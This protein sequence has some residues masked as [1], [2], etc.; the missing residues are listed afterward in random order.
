M[1]S[2]PIEQ[3]TIELIDRG[4]LSAPAEW[5]QLT[6]G[7]SNRVWHLR[8]N[9]DLDLC[10]KLYPKHPWQN[11]LFPNDPIREHACL[12]ALAPHGISPKPVAFIEASVGPCLIYEHISG[13]ILDDQVTL[14]AQ[15]LAQLHQLPA[16]D[17]F[18]LLYT[19]PS[20][21]DAHESRMP[22]SA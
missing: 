22:S 11:P 8:T 2:L 20:P 5:T 3:L 1:K 18:C 19:S 6:G 9:N 12:K 14:I 16:L 7:R 10:V 17:G 4:I 21:R 13:T 15:C